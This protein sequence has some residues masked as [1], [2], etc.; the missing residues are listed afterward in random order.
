[1]NSYP[2]FSLQNFDLQRK[3]IFYPKADLSFMGLAEQN[4]KKPFADD[5]LTFLPLIDDICLQENL[6]IP[7]SI[8]PLTAHGTMHCAYIATTNN[9]KKYV[10]RINRFSKQRQACEFYI[11]TFIYQLLAQQGIQNITVLA[12]HCLKTEPFID[13][14]IMEYIDGQSATTYENK[15]TQALDER[16][17]QSIG[18]RLA[19]F[20]TIKTTGYGLLSVSAIIN[21]K[22]L[23]GLHQTWSSYILKNF[24]QHTQ[25]CQ[26]I[27]AISYAETS[28][29]I[30]LFYQHI[31]LFENVRPALLHGDPGGHN[32][33]CSDAYTVHAFIDFED[34]L[35]GDWVYDIAFWGTFYKDWMLQPLL[36]GYTQQ[37]NSPIPNNFYTRYWLYYL[38]ISI[39]KTVHRHLFGYKD[40][41]GRPRPSLRIQKALERLTTSP[42]LESENL[43]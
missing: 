1:M 35:S 14:H 28:K 5:L 3:H 23:W 18:A 19:L 9:N 33:L 7:K 26:S 12:A 21:D 2:L 43:L 34:C 32:V 39:A 20:H 8:T 41:S 13:Y 29:I 6:G 16:L 37:N 15:Q 30:E 22:K 11:E 25:I 31:S 42:L 17:L 40:T 24:E 36:C 27:G 4:I 38:R 10:I